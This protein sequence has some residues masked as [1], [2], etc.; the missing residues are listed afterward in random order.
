MPFTRVV[1]LLEAFA[2]PAQKVVGEHADKD[3]P[4]D[5]VFELM[6]IRPQSEGA[7]ELAEASFGFEERHVEFPELHGF[8]APVGLQNIVT[9]L[10][11]GTFHFLLVAGDFESP[12][13]VFECV[14]S[15]RAGLSFLEGSDFAF[16]DGSAFENAF[17]DA[18]GEGCCG[19]EEA[20]L[21]AGNH[22][23]FLEAA[24][25]AA[26]QDQMA[27]GVLGVGDS[28]HL[29]TLFIGASGQGLEGLFFKSIGILGAAAARDVDEVGIASLLEHGEVGARGESS[30]EDDHGLETILMAGEAIE[31]NGQGFGVAHVA[32]EG[33]VGEWK[34]VFVK[35]D[36]H[37][38]LTAVV[39]VLLV[40]SVFGFWI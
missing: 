11:D 28:F 22:G 36:A 33:L 16:D 6:E 5:A 12:G 13:V 32:L 29:H 15:R 35:G 21:C 37:G 25:G 38:D 23:L 26:T 4:V 30:V 14:K 9:A 18:F 20:L 39:A 17:F 34:T 2:D 40:F 19:S 1:V 24:L 7:F 27:R 8:E 31:N 3:V 10:G